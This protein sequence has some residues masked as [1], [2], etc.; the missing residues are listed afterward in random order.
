MVVGGWLLGLV[1]CTT[2]P[3]PEGAVPDLGWIG[4][5]SR[6]PA[7]F[8]ALMTS[9]GRDGWVQLHA[10]DDARATATFGDDLTLRSRPA[11]KVAMLERDLA[12]LSATAHERLFTAW[13]AR[14]PLP[15]GAAAIAA[16]S[17][18]CGDGDPDAWAARVPAGD[19]GAELVAR[20]SIAPDSWASPVDEATARLAAH[21]AALSTDPLAPWDRPD[22]PVLEIPGD[23]PR[24]WF[25]PCFHQVASVHAERVAV[26]GSWV[27]A[28][29]G[30]AAGDLRG[31][32]FAPWLTGDDLKA[33]AGPTSSPG[34][35]GAD[36]PVVHG[37]LD[38]AGLP[39][40][41]DD[42]QAAREQARV[43]TERLTQRAGALEATAAPDGQALLIELGLAEHWRQ[44]WHLAQARR[45]LAADRP[46]QALALAELGTDFSAE[47]GPGN[48][49][50]LYAVRAHALLRLGRTREALD[51]LHPLR[52][53]RGVA[54]LEEVLGDL[55]VLE[56]LDRDG[57]SKEN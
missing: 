49:P 48:P 37:L 54:Q 55:A 57:D 16:W 18:W 43:L 27:D 17:A 26:G 32:L 10:H 29:A 11:W 4:V 45:A 31:V 50:G 23:P 24:V 52:P 47:P 13:A 36:S 5:V 38:E 46:Q 19:P 1:G 56:G 39:G 7:S 40:A 6:D 21:H 22:A 14:G 41:T 15:P 20:L 42:P 53:H 9:T 3:Q 35:W 8:S 28:A 33:E 44:Q 2:P 34:T 51:A 30:W 12:G 25:D